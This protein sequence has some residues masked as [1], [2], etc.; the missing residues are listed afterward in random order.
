MSTG[1]GQTRGT[2]QHTFSKFH[3]RAI[4]LLRAETEPDAVVAVTHPLAWIFM[5]WC[6][7]PTLSI[8]MDI[9]TPEQWVHF[10]DDLKPDY[11]LLTTPAAQHFDGY[12]GLVIRS[13]KYRLVRLYAVETS[14]RP[15]DRWKPPM[16]LACAGLETCIS[17]PR[18]SDAHRRFSSMSFPAYQ[19][20]S[21]RDWSSLGSAGGVMTVPRAGTKPLGSGRL[22]TGRR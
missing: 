3:D 9:R 1:S 7:N 18:R 22:P 21:R 16:P 6:G 10:R 19:L 13:E 2:R 4:G 11:A 14:G 8:P 15:G 5:L 17:R 20:A 12:E